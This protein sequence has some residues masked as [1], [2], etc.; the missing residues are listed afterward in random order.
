M[1][2]QLSLAYRCLRKTG[3]KRCV[4]SRRSVLGF[5]TQSIEQATDF[6]SVS[7]VPRTAAGRLSQY[8]LLLKAG[9][10]KKGQGRK[11]LK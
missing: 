11:S 4:G 3:K 5:R 1:A 9:V 10:T 7:Y 2:K 6:D 8:A